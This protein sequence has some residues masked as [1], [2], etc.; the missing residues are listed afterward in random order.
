VTE[1][2]LE[3]KD[4][5]VRFAVRG[6]PWHRSPGHIV[7]V[8]SVSLTINAGQTW[9]LVGESGCGKSSLARAIVGLVPVASGSV[10]VAGHELLRLK[11][12]AARQH[13]RLVQM[14]FQDPYGSLNPRQ[15]AHGSL[16]Q[17]CLSLLQEVGLGGDI[18]DCYPHELSGGQRQ[19]VAIARA[20]A[21]RPRVVVAD[22]PTSALDVTVQARILNLL[23]QLQVRHGL[24]LLLISHDLH[25]VR[26]MAQQVAVMYL[27]Q[28]VETF[29]VKE[30]RAPLHPYGQALEAAAPS[31]RKRLTSQAVPASGGEAPSLL[32]LPAGCPYHPRCHRCEPSCR[33]DPPQLSVA[34]G[35]HLVRC[36]VALRNTA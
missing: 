32:Q 10:R 24:A 26:Q 7:P 14:V 6:K 29:P 18:L 17:E 25:L 8:S 11:G 3:I 13:R 28:L 19:R 15:A 1:A 34:G 36:P 33:I 16:A 20:L 5:V 9:A 21:V 27:G 22:E 30:T 23:R 4:L 31:L 35:G 2:V 12:E